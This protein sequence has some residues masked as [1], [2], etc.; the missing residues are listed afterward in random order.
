M[1]I[2]KLGEMVDTHSTVKRKEI[3]RV[4]CWSISHVHFVLVL[5]IILVS[6][7]TVCTEVQEAL[8]FEECCTQEAGVR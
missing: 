6:V 8:T 2:I 1:D 3:V 5:V 4:K 7:H